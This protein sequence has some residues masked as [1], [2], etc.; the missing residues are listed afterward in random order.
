MS[1][2]EGFG[3]S[4]AQSF[5]AAQAQQA[6]MREDQFKMSY[7][8]FM[9]KR[10]QLIQ[11]KAQDVKDANDSQA[12]IQSVGGAIPP[13]AWPQVY[14]WKKAG[15]D[16]ATIRD[17]LVRGNFTIDKNVYQQPQMPK[18]GDI[19]GQSNQAFG[20]QS[21]DQAG[22]S[23]AGMMNGQPQGTAQQNAG[24]QGQG[25]GAHPKLLGN[26]APAVGQH[27][28]PPGNVGPQQPQSPD[29]QFGGTQDQM[30]QPQPQGGIRGFF[31]N[32]RQGQYQR[33][34]NMANQRIGAAAGVDPSQI[35][36]VIGAP[37]M[38]TQVSTKGIN[39]TPGAVIDPKLDQYDTL[40]KLATALADAKAKGDSTLIKNL[41]TRYDA[42]IGNKKVENQ[43]AFEVQD[44]VEAQK[45]LNAAQHAI[46]PALK[47]HQDRV[48]EYNEALRSA[49]NMMDILDSPGGNGVLAR[50][51]SEGAKKMQQYGADA[52]VTADNV[53]KF[54][55]VGGNGTIDGG[56]SWVKQ[57]QEKILHSGSQED[58]GTKAA[59][60]DLNRDNFALHMMKAMKQ[61]GGMSSG[62]FI[63]KIYGEHT[64]LNN[65]DTFKQGMADTMLNLKKEL[66]SDQQAIFD[67]SP[68]VRG[69]MTQRV[70]DKGEDMYGL[71]HSSL[72]PNTY[73]TT[74]D[75][76]LR[77]DKQLTGVL[78]KLQKYNRQ[79]PTSQSHLITLQN[80]Q[81]AIA[82]NDPSDVANIPDKDQNGNDNIVASPDGTTHRVSDVKAFLKAQQ[83]APSPQQA[84][85]PIQR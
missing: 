51:A 32:L 67:K 73:K 9:D 24:P 52:T 70:N 54:L 34:V 63:S 6:Q 69:Y 18:Y 33:N 50:W 80:G 44:R 40:P 37:V 82:V 43:M 11:Q 72:D 38:P 61:S 17:N 28:T 77:N 5:N 10:Q 29:Q 53:A 31:D 45:E 59:L 79:D 3:E 84:Q 78:A 41:Q 1:F 19:Y 26:M 21:N 15:L 12:L 57:Q 85:P 7:Q 65:P 36:N 66:D 22:S 74:D 14:A 75:A 30:G 23:P 49:D 13:E 39:F 58:L 16:D 60:F 35:E 48:T 27:P 47:E 71:N 81:K 62:E 68:E 42:A 83:A 4:F 8:L 76:A 56:I 2:A 55:G 46:A 20:G 25:A 64:E